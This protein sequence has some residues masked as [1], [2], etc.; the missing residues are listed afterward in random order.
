MVIQKE[1]FPF[2]RPSYNYNFEP[3]TCMCKKTNMPIH[4]TTKQGGAKTALY[5]STSSMDV[6][7]SLRLFAICICICSFYRHSHDTTP[8]QRHLGFVPTPQFS[9]KK[10]LLHFVA[11]KD[12]IC[13]RLCCLMSIHIL[14]SI[15]CLSI[16][17]NNIQ[18]GYD[19]VGCIHHEFVAA[20]LTQQYQ[21]LC[22]AS[23]FTPRSHHHLPIPTCL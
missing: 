10:N 7:C 21:V 9:K 15:P 19:R 11:H 22:R 13:K 17:N 8:S 14:H 16:D 1:E 20:T 6:G 3:I 2:A 12:E 4:T 5:F 18:Y 23:S